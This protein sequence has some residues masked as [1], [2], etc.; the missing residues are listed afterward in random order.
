MYLVIGISIIDCVSFHS[1]LNETK[2][3]R[4]GFSLIVEQTVG[5]GTHK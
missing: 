2:K 1:G 3:I 5:E 4:I